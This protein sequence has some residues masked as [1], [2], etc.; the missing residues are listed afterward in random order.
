[1]S[2]RRSNASFN[3]NS[4][5]GSVR[6]TPKIPPRLPIQLL[7][8]LRLKT[9]K[10]LPMR[11]QLMKIRKANRQTLPQMAKSLPRVSLPKVNPQTTLPQTS[12]PT[13]QRKTQKM[14]TR[15]RMSPP[16]SFPTRK[17]LQSLNLSAKTTITLFISTENLKESVF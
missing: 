13:K 16:S 14:K 2:A 10:M 6:K 12:P 15:T 5:Y 7:P 4:T 11:L 9:P 1:M 17:S 3:H 8:T